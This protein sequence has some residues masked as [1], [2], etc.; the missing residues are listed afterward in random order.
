MLVAIYGSQGSGKSTT[1]DILKQN[2]CN[3]IERKT[4]RSILED[5][6][7]SLQEV[8]A[9][10]DL[11]I[12]FQDE[13]TK[14]KYNDEA[15]YIDCEEIWFTERTHT[16]LFVYALASIGKDNQYSD[17]MDHYYDTCKKYNESYSMVF[18]LPH[19]VFD[20]VADGVRGNNRHYAK[21][22]DLMMSHFQMDMYN[23]YRHVIEEHSPHSRGC[24]IERVIQ[25]QLNK[26]IPFN[27]V[28]ISH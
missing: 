15:Q 25:K 20:V 26:V 22:I 27:P 2:G 14:R 11:T 16:D 28:V 12:R 8:N 7:V 21:T 1:L 17:W 24:E 10:P 13:I 23:G 4:S 6:N 18:Q 5:W 19:G 3:V 9:T